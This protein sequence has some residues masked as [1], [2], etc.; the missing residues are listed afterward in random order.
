MLEDCRPQAY[1]QK[2]AKVEIKVPDATVFQPEEKGLTVNTDLSVG[3]FLLTADNEA[4]V[5]GIMLFDGFVDD[6]ERQILVLS[7]SKKRGN[8][9]KGGVNTGVLSTERKSTSDVV[10]LL[11]LMRDA[12]AKLPLAVREAF[13]VLDLFTD[14]IGPARDWVGA[15]LVLVG[16]EALIITEWKH[17]D[18]VM[19]GLAGSRE[20]FRCNWYY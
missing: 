10:P 14:W 9:T 13:V 18:S 5:D 15:N 3:K 6:E 4:G 16:D 17:L 20:R 1:C 7:Q 11:P 2:N 12:K 8:S 19:G